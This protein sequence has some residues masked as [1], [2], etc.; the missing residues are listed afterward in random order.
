VTA[1]SHAI[2]LSFDLVLEQSPQLALTKPTVSSYK[3][4]N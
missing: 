3:A 2:S 4:H 1:D